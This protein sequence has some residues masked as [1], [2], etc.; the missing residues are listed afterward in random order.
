MNLPT[1]VFGNVVVVHAPEELTEAR[2]EEL[3]PC[4]TSL[5]RHNVVLDLNP[6]EVLDSKGLE[7]IWDGLDALR[8]L[9][10]ELKISTDN[11]VNRKIMEI[12]RL[13][14]QVEVFESVVDAVRSFA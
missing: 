4:L 6:I 8:E 1:E 11:A 14:L 7:A 12:T 13:D 9:D 10:G 5:E 2:C 3:V